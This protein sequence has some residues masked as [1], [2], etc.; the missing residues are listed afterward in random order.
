[1]H[2]IIAVA[3]HKGGVGK[4]AIAQNVGALLAE[5]GRRVLLVD[6]DPQSSLTGA[7]GIEDTER[8]LASVLGGADEGHLAMVDIIRPVGERLDLAPSDIS[9]AAAEL[10]MIGRVGRENVLKRVLA[11]LG[12]RYD[13]TVID[14]PPSLA[15]LTINALNASAGVLIP[16]QPQAADLRGLKLFLQTLEQLRR[17]LDR[18]DLS[19]V[20]I[21]PTFYDSRLVHH[22]DAIE[23]MARGRLNVL[24]PI[25][26]TV[27]FAEAV[28]AGK[29]LHQYEPGNVQVDALRTLTGQVETWLRSRA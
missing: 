16:T 5:G 15:V 21:V 8:N 22:R 25:G 20:G 12:G 14:C 26:R 13:V 23:A 17:G 28:A 24:T 4:T 7:F 6:V 3:N 29:P 2:C 19:I 18:D 27:K 9:L 11:P 1:M 10:G